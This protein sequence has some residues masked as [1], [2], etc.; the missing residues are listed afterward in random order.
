MTWKVNNM[1]YYNTLDTFKRQIFCPN[2]QEPPKVNFDSYK[3]IK[4]DVHGCTLE[5]SKILR[6]RKIV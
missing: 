5:D 1:I 3:V 6:C 2:V 4:G